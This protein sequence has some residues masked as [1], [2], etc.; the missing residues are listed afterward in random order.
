MQTATISEYLA[1]RT[2]LIQQHWTE[3]TVLATYEH[4]NEPSATAVL[5]GFLG[6][7]HWNYGQ[8]PSSQREDGYRWVGRELGKA[9]V[10]LAEEQTILDLVQDDDDHRFVMGFDDRLA[11]FDR[12]LRAIC[13]R[14]LSVI[15]RDSFECD[16]SDADLRVLTGHRQIVRGWRDATNKIL[17]LSVPAIAE[18][19][20]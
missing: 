4:M 2:R 19:A 20:A 5:W 8:R 11:I 1:N 14:P 9:I 12:N 10:R 18:V 3:E 6:D 7:W 13:D 17:A 15:L 16:L